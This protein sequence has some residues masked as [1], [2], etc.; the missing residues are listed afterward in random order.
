MIIYEWEGERVSARHKLLLSYNDRA[1]KKKQENFVVV[2]ICTMEVP[3]KKKK[4]KVTFRRVVLYICSLKFSK[5][6]RMCKSERE[7][8]EK[9]SV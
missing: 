1:T 8:N 5:H 3:M 9:I 4:I 6:K 2:S 7:M